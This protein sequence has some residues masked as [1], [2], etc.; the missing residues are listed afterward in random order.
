MESHRHIFRFVT[1]TAVFVGQ[2]LCSGG[3]SCCRAADFG[4]GFGGVHVTSVG[5]LPQN[6]PPY[7]TNCLSDI[8]DSI[9]NN[10][11]TAVPIKNPLAFKIN[12]LYS[13][14]LI[15]E[16][17]VE[18]DFGRGWSAG[19]GWMYGWWKRDSNH[20]YWRAY[21]GYATV[22]KYLGPQH[23]DRPLTGHH[24]GLYAQL[25]TYD[26]EF[27][28]TGY[29]AGQPGGTLWDKAN[30][31]FGVEYGFSLYSS[32]SIRFDFSMGVGYLG[33]TYYEYTPMN[34]H[35]VWDATKSRHWFGPTKA[36][37]SIVWLIDLSSH[38]QK[39]GGCR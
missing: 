7:L 34:G 15:P 25:L 1:C 18:Y 31:G 38:K 37:V 9:Y 8:S 12:L 3:V 36:E 5:E 27:G 20:H 16:V 32:R 23:I 13:L 4:D 17:G 24:V 10:V 39:K 26:V 29:M 33:G 2:V 11:E 22:R 6:T 28:G 21:G 30:Y 14:F 19:A 35:Y